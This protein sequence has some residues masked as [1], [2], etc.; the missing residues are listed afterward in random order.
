MSVHHRGSCHRRAEEDT[1]G[2]AIETCRL[3]KEL[4]GGGSLTLA[5]SRDTDNNE[6]DTREEHGKVEE[7]ARRSKDQFDCASVHFGLL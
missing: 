6:P 3:A 7:D 4:D 2:E 5:N 1:N